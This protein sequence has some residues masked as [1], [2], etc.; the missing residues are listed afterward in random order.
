MKHLCRKVI[1]ILLVMAIVFHTNAVSAAVINNDAV[2]PVATNA[3]Q[4]WV[5][6]AEVSSET[7]IVMDADTGAI[8]YNKGMDELRYPA[9]ITKVMTA[10][11]VLENCSL[12]DQVTFTEACLGDQT[13]DSS[14]AAM[15]VGEILTVEQCLMLLMLKSAND[16][17]TQLGVHVA[18]DITAFSQMMNTRAQELGCK[19]THFVNA[20]GMPDENHYTTAY[21]M[22]LIFREAIKNEDFLRI[23]GTIEFVLPPTNMNGETRSFRTHHELLIEGSSLYCEGCFGGKTGGSSI[24]KNTLI[25]GATRNEMTLIVVSMRTDIMSIWNDH[26]AL[27]EYGFNNF[28]QA[29]VLGGK[30]TIPITCT[31]DNLT[32]QDVPGGEQIVQQYY[33][34]TQFVGTGLKPAEEISVEIEEEIVESEPVELTEIIEEQTEE[35]GSAFEDTVTIIVYVLVGMNIFFVFVLICAAVKHRKSKKRKKS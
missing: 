28:Q 27:F 13:S 34:D 8:L 18:G 32:T 3:I 19:N 24:S 11:L 6:G 14:N 22:A 16:V 21:D 23:I 25:S 29:E 20:S 31:V 26:L 12:S 5:Q 15:Q 1:G 7:A 17:A 33:L 10:L 35:S 9:S 30:V 2:Y 4:G